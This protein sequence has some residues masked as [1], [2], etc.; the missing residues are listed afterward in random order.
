MDNSFD[1]YGSRHGVEPTCTQGTGGHLHGQSSARM[2]E[3][4]GEKLGC[5]GGVIRDHEIL[6]TVHCE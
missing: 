3:L 1:A 6:G 5:T 4:V 2:I